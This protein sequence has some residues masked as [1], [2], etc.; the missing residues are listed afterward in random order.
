MFGVISDYK[1]YNR[2]R[3][4]IFGIDE[5]EPNILYLN[6]PVLENTS[7][8]NDNNVILDPILHIDNMA[9]MNSIGDSPIIYNN[10]CLDMEHNHINLP[11]KVYLFRIFLYHFVQKHIC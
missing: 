2:H 1:F 10:E 11:F 8:I 6:A 4:E 9:N 7:T 3:D 5:T